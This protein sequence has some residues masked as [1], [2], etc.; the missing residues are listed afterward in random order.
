RGHGRHVVYARVTGYLGDRDIPGAGH[1]PLG[2][3]GGPPTLYER[4][5]LAPG[6]VPDRNRKPGIQ[7]V[8]G[9]GTSHDPQADKA[10]ALA[11][12]P[13][14]S[15]GIRSRTPAGPLRSHPGN[16]PRCPVFPPPGE[17][18]R[19]SP[20]RGRTKL[21]IM[22]PFVLPPGALVVRRPAPSR[23]VAL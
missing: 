16:A 4:G 14:T 6:A 5:R 19:R 13:I 23:Q 9:H 1:P 21:V 17:A 10:D 7:H 18:Q 12:P 22:L 8:P 2:G 20:F 3:A 11:H 15:L